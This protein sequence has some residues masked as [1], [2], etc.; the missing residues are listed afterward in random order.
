MSQGTILS[1]GKTNESN[2]S[3]TAKGTGKEFEI[4]IKRNGIKVK[5]A[6]VYADKAK[7][8]STG[9]APLILSLGARWR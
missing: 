9:T 1:E 4:R 8:R 3:N 6:L 7:G 2:E 5:Y